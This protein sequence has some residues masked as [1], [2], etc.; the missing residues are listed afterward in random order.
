MLWKWMS[1]QTVV[2]KRC[3][4]DV[5]IIYCAKENLAFNYDNQFNLKC[6][7]NYQQYYKYVCTC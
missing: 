4:S 1:V 2:Q 5:Y 3:I 7:A 6:L